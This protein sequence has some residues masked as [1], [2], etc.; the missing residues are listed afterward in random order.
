MGKRS[1]TDLKMSAASGQNVIVRAEVWTSCRLDGSKD[2]WLRVGTGFTRVDCTVTRVHCLELPFSMS[3]GQG[4]KK[5]QFDVVSK[6]EHVL[7]TRNR[8]IP[9]N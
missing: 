4:Q 5:N 8:N 6:I 7:L 1:V 3:Q 2:D 9:A